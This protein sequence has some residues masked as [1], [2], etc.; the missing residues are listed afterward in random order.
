MLGHVIAGIAERLD[1]EEDV[2]QVVTQ[3]QG[4]L[5]GRCRLGQGTQAGPTQF[6]HP[7][8]HRL[9]LVAFA[10]APVL[11]VVQDVRP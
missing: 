4:L 6:L 3:P 5:R 7:D 2:V 9:V 1:D 11:H 8:R 10:P